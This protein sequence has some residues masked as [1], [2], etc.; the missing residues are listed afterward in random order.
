MLSGDT[1]QFESLR[2]DGRSDLS[3][4]LQ[5][6]GG[7]L[8]L[9]ERTPWYELDKPLATLDTR[10]RNLEEYRAGKRTLDILDADG[11]VIGSVD[12]EKGTV[13]LTPEAHQA[14]DALRTTMSRERGV[15]A[16]PELSTTYWRAKTAARNAD[17]CEQPGQNHH[18]V[19]VD[20]M[21][22]HQDFFEEIGFN[23]DKGLSGQGGAQNVIRLPATEA[24]RAAMKNDAACG[25]RTIHNGPHNEYAKAIDAQ[26]ERIRGQLDSGKIG[27][28]EA[29]AKLSR[30]MDLTRQELLSG[31]YSTMNDPALARAIEGFRL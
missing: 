11:K 5:L 7:K 22:D 15:P 21:K 24:Q 1:P 27:V 18:V 12:R 26:I 29:R 13:S 17:P 2:V 16:H 10:I 6:Y 31:R 4:T 14:L 28:Q 19:P 8:T 9:S 23:L 20:L 25:D 3:A 30:L